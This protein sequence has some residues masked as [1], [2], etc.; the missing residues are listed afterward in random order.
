[1]F[2][3]VDRLCPE[4]IR[5]FATYGEDVSDMCLDCAVTIFTKIDRE[6]QEKI[7]KAKEVLQWATKQAMQCVEISTLQVPAGSSVESKGIVSGYSVIGTGVFTEIASAWTDFFGMESGAYFEKIRTGEDRAIGMAKLKALRLGA[8]A[9]YGATL[10]VTEATK[11]NGML[12]ISWRRHR[13]N[14]ASLKTCRI[15]SSRQILT[16]MSGTGSS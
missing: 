7:A 2:N 16:T 15:L 5:D 3:K 1:M 4:T 6:K 11:G 9:I 13:K 14:F 8:N 12:I 10:N